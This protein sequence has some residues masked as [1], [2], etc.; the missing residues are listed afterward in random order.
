MTARPT[1]PVKISWDKDPGATAGYDLY[2]N[3]AKVASA[4]AK[5]ISTMA[6]LA[7]G[8]LFEVVGKPSGLRQQVTV[9]WHSVDVQPVPPP[10]PSTLTIGLT[11]DK[12]GGKVLTS[13][14]NAA[15]AEWARTSTASSSDPEYAT[16]ALDA[17]F[18]GTSA[19]PWVSAIA[20]D[21]AGTKIG[22]AFTARIQTTQSVVPPPPPPPPSGSVRFGISENIGGG[23]NKAALLTLGAKIIR[24]DTAVAN[25]WA[26][27][28]GID[29]I[30]IISVGGTSHAD[31]GS[32]CFEAGG[33]EPQQA[34]V[35]P[36][37]WA[38]ATHADVKTLRAKFP[39]TPVIITLCAIGQ[40]Y[41]NNGQDQNGNYVYPNSGTPSKSWVSQIDAAAPGLLA[42]VQG[43]SVHPYFNVPPFRVLDIV[44]SEL[45]ALGHE[46]P[47]WITEAGMYTSLDHSGDANQAAV[48]KA[49]IAAAKARSDVY[50]YIAYRLG[51]ASEGSASWG[52]LNPDGSQRPAYA[53]FKAAV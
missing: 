6:T 37:V 22:S 29:V 12:T 47:F 16:Q 8:D 30:Q 10:P 28:N 50:C 1:Q 18:P 5:A 49:E 26:K 40:Y 48:F 13:P 24:E 3:G 46:Q 35:D 15:K 52:L 2:R 23:G 11:T 42:D 9:S 43:F 21:S 33:N 45:H 4:S 31:A 34:G 20:L 39:N 19:K 36:K 53:V 44:R 51:A 25:S 17:P 7:T 32:F 41:G 27:T 38:P 14:A